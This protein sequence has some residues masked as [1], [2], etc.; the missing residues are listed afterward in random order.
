M[1]FIPCFTLCLT[2]LLYIWCS[3]VNTIMSYVN[4]RLS[5]CLPSLPHH[6]S[7]KRF[8]LKQQKISPHYL[9]ILLTNR[10]ITKLFSIQPTPSKEYHLSPKGVSLIA[11]FI[12]FISFIFLAT[13]HYLLA[14]SS[15]SSHIIHSFTISWYRYS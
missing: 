4:Q 14:P 8:Q 2:V 3:L 6:P 12:T 15:P 1:L 7:L 5:T 13:P 9:K 11:L 10:Y